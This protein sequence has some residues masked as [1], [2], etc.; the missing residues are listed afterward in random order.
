MLISGSHNASIGNKPFKD[1]LESY[2]QNPLLNQ[3]A[4]IKTLK[5]GDDV[6]PIWDMTAIDKRHVILHDFAIQKWNFDSV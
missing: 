1:K 3:Q 4:E 6:T 2:K 5:S